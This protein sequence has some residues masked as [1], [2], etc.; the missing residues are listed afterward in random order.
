MLAIKIENKEFESKFLEFAKS[1]KKAVE[2]IKYFINSKNNDT[3]VYT[4]KIH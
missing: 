3:L 2:A 1:Q 4:K